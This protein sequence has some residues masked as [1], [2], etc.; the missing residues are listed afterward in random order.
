M[1]AFVYYDR[2][3]LNQTDMSNSLEQKAPE[4]EL[5]F[6]SSSVIVGR[7]ILC[8]VAFACICVRVRVCKNVLYS[9]NSRNECGFNI[10]SFSKLSTQL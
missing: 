10:F 3:V 5:H 8:Y 1:C 9:N 4:P 6:H 7:Y 2:T